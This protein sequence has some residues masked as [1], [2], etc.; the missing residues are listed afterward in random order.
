MVFCPPIRH[1]HFHHHFVL[2]VFVTLYCCEFFK[3]ANSCKPTVYSFNFSLFR[4]CKCE[5]SVVSC[6]NLEYFDSQLKTDDIYGI[7]I[8][9]FRYACCDSHLFSWNLNL[10]KVL[11]ISP[12]VLIHWTF[13]DHLADDSCTKYLWIKRNRTSLKSNIQLANKNILFSTYGGWIFR[14]FSIFRVEHDFS[15]LK[16]DNLQKRTF[17]CPS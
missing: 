13:M 2:V 14:N 16:N 10:S 3:Y 1:N 8:L 9:A 6:R 7:L 5:A 15:V 17:V 4:D 11:W 12:C